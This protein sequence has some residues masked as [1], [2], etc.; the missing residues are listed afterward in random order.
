MVEATGLNSMESRSS[1]MS[2]SSYKISSKSTNRFKSCTTSKFNR[3]PF[4][5]DRRHLQCHH[6]H[7]KFQPNPPNSSNVIRGSFHAPQ[8]FKR[9]PFWN[10][11]TGLSSIE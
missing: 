11:A 5:S 8:R 9:P 10:E 2:S 7:T 3:P 6:L 4:W 1:S